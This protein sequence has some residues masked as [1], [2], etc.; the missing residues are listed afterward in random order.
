MSGGEPNDQP[1]DGVKVAD[2]SDSVAGQLGGRLFADSGALVTLYEPDGGS[3][4]RRVPPMESRSQQSLLFRHLNWG[5]GKSPRPGHPGWRELEEFDVVLVSEWALA[6]A[7][8]ISLPDLIVG[9]VGDFP[10]RG[11]YR[12][13]QGSEL[14]FQALS[15]SMYS[16]GLADREPLYGIGRRAEY[17][18]GLNLF[19]G[20]MSALV[21]RETSSR[22]GQL[23]STSVYESAV[24][25]EQNFST[26]WSYSGVLARRGDLRRPRA[27]LPSRDGWVVTF[28]LPG[29]LNATL[30]LLDAVD[31]L[32]DP[33]FQQWNSFM[34]S[35]GECVALMAERSRG[36]TNAYLLD[37][38]R[39]RGVVLAPI[40]TIQD[41]LVDADLSVKRFWRHDVDLDGNS[42]IRLGPMFVSQ[43][44]PSPESVDVRPE[45]DDRSDG[46]LTGIRVIDFTTAW[47]GPMASRILGYLG[48]DIIKIEG[49]NRPDGWRGEERPAIRDYYPGG[50]PGQDPRNR[51]SWFNTQNTNK[52]SLV[53]DL[54]DRRGR[55]LV[56]QLIG[57]ADVVMSNFS[58]GTM[59]R[60]GL[61]SQKLAAI[62]PGIVTLEMS[63][64]GATGALAG[65][66]GLGP[67]MEATSGIT[68]MIGYRDLPALG[69]G[70]AYL[71]PMGAL[72]GASAVLVGLLGRKRDGD[73]RHLT[74][75]QREAATH[76]IGELFLDAAVN[77]SDPGPKGNDHDEACPHGA[78]P[79]LGDDEWVALGIFD[80][81]QWASLCRLAGW[82]EWIGMT[83]AGRVDA[84]D[85]IAGRLRAWTSRFDK[86]S[87][88][89][90]LQA[91]GVP[92]SPVCHGRDLYE[93]VQL[94]GVDWFAPLAH[95]SSGVHEYPRSPIHLSS[96]PGR[97]RMPAPRFG[98]HSMQ[99]LSELGVRSEQLTRMVSAGVVVAPVVPHP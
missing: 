39:Q 30:Q 76:W 4:I 18:A 83:M 35:F 25:M 67:T 92:A 69:S 19:I 78:Y 65:M 80:D 42:G 33:R 13:W 16:N 6:E 54:K 43:A 26:Q 22:P 23:V 89:W 57:T 3:R 98:E 21:S 37:E 15:G 72:M 73:G 14:I 24:S 90:E 55:D 64:Y 61:D 59:E 53:V 99:V 1:L 51:N 62:R 45:I 96:T 84:K 60:L 27:A 5:K 12:S 41:L 68:S 48:A 79:A 88:S 36:Y 17:A 66:K 97:L 11:P 87:L 8:R 52:R 34:T 38:A 86:D 20:V 70:S 47:S 29:T 93:S 9:Y 46:P 2:V 95:P 58:P 94:R 44:M 75:C 49:P 7:A 91:T 63:A 32:A 74:L 71:D 56:E 28:V 81:D 77:G 10:Q 31:L 82:D 85:E 50:D 40:S